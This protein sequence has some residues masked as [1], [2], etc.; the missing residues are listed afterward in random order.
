MTD[1]L[2][3]L[4][5]R[6]KAFVEARDWEQFH[7]PKSTAMALSVETSELVELFQ[8]HDNLSAD[9][10]KDDPDIRD[11]VADELADVLIYVLSISAQFDIDLIEATDE[12]LDR[13]D[14]RYDEQR[15]AQIREE[16]SS[17]TVDCSE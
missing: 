14:E 17:W 12:K 1:D 16:L 2:D 15:A 7:T 9:A 3:D 11:A 4:R 5:K 10:Y 6:Q 8:W 13:N